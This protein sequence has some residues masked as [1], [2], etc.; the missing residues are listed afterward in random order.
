MNN[1]A[2]KLDLLIE[3]D[4]EFAIY[5]LP[6]GS[7]PQF[8]MQD[9][10]ETKCLYDIEKLE[11][12]TG[13][14]IAPFRISN[15]N[16]L[17]IISPDI[18]NL[19]DAA[20]PL[21]K[22]LINQNRNEPVRNIDRS[23][24]NK[25]FNL[26]YRP[27]S[28]G[29]MKKIVLSR[30]KSIPKN[31]NFSPGKCFYRAMEKY[32]QSYVFLFHTRKSGTWLGSSPELLLSGKGNS[33]QT[34]ALAGTKYPKK[35]I[36]SWDD[37]NLREQH[38]VTSYLLSHLSSIN[39]NAEING[40]YTT[41]AGSLAHLKTDLNFYLPDDINLGKLLNSF[42]PTPAISGLPK[43]EAYQFIEENE[44][45]DRR[46]YTGFLGM[47]SRN[48]AT[49]IYVNLRSMEIKESLITLFSGSGLITSSNCRDEW[50]ETEQKLKTM[51]SIIN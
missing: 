22:K 29:A 35:G 12:N 48:S 44:G 3:N 24:Y 27:L 20:V 21:N 37:K 4:A 15:D 1:N 9:S 5:R 38:L 17:I 39:I 19:A 32:K 50:K 2:H 46:Y 41:I 30:S 10:G 45:Y 43:I 49:N 33:W 23:E 31:K 40:P 47:L 7:H 11:G 42:H 14:V 36:V 16:P 28:E 18:T 8:V 26:F 13:F 51:A 6:N 34:V 25:L